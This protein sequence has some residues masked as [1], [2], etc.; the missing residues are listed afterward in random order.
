MKQPMR[1]VQPLAALQEPSA[2][3]PSNAFASSALRTLR[4]ARAARYPAVAAGPEPRHV[5]VIGLRD[6]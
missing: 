1:A 2:R 4:A 3:E 5:A 6:P